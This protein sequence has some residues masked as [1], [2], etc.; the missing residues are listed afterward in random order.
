MKTSRRPLHLNKVRN[1]KV[2][3]LGTGAVAFEQVPEKDAGSG[4]DDEEVEHSTV[5]EIA[6]VPSDTTSVVVTEV[7][8]D[9]T[10]AVEGAIDAAIS[11]MD[12]TVEEDAPDEIP[13][14]NGS[15]SWHNTGGNIV[16]GRRRGRVDH[17]DAR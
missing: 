8:G 5:I 9:I 15:A 13:A 1:R 6:S 14:S 11:S 10:E 4:L 17:H 12:E 7:P 2:A 16:V 3:G